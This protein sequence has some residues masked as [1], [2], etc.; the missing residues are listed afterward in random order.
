VLFVA[1]YEQFG[2]SPYYAFDN[3]ALGLVDFRAGFELPKGAIAKQKLSVRT[4]TLDP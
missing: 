1:G 4:G 3:S 2:V